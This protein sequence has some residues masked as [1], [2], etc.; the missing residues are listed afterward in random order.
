MK[1]RE[2]RLRDWLFGEKL[3]NRNCVGFACMLFPALQGRHDGLS[4]GEA[5]RFFFL[6]S[7][8]RG[9]GSRK[10]GVLGI[11]GF[12]A[13]FGKRT[14][15]LSGI[16]FRNGIRP[17]GVGDGKHPREWFVAKSRHTLMF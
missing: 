11:S 4:R 17:W 3:E 2:R 12:G 6:E 13:D 10:S 9:E 5:A 1:C 7:N 8:L 16:A 14:G 15:K